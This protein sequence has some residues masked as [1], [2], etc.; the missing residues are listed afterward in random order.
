MDII[1]KFKEMNKSF[2]NHHVLKNINVEFNKGET[3][4]ILGPSG[5]GKSTLLRC[6]NLLEIPQTGTL[7]IDSLKVDFTQK[8]SQKDKLLIRQN[9][10]MV[11]QSFNL[12]PHMT[13][14]EN[15][16]EGPI[17]VLKKDK[18]KM[19]QI[20]EQLL[21]KVGL[22][23]KKDSYPSQLSGGQQQR[24]AIARALAMEPKFL[25]FDEPTSALDPELEG[26]VLKV[27]KALSEEQKSMILVTHNLNF[28]RVAADRILFLENGEILFDGRTDEFFNNTENE[29]IISFIQS[30][31][32]I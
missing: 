24:V 3:T 29:R 32:F 26:E 15:V 16:I 22:L 11:F 14:L 13:V 23:H 12:F 9:T 5:S 7:E 31:Q 19:I 21:E 8:L 6:I 30:M 18:S 2:Q 1:V 20:G 28:A 17:T 4:V 10:A 27:L 25:L